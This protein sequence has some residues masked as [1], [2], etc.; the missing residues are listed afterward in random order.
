VIL[1]NNHKHNRKI[2]IS[3][4]LNLI[5]RVK[6]MAGNVNLFEMAKRQFDGVAKELGL[7]EATCNLLRQHDK[8]LSFNIPIRMD[9]GS[10]QVF[11][12]FRCL[13]NDARGPGKGGIRFDPNETIDDVRALS[14]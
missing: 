2:I 1:K 13:H 9:D 11:R 5:K 14:M 8:E 10:Y 4:F 6:T 3:Y 12:G 7:D